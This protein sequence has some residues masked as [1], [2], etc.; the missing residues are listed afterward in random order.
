MINFISTILMS[1]I[2]FVAVPASADIIGVTVHGEFACEV[3]ALDDNAQKL[4][5]RWIELNRKRV[6]QT[7]TQEEADEGSELNSTRCGTLLGGVAAELLQTDGV[8]YLV[9]LCDETGCSVSIMKSDGF[10]RD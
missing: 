6:D 2:L 4:L 3:D 9:K 1:L 7:L 10:Q 8:D 5:N